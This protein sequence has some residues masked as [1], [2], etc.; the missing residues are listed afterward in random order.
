VREIILGFSKIETIN[1]TENVQIEAIVCPVDIN[2]R[3]AYQHARTTLVNLTDIPL[4]KLRSTFNVDSI[5]NDQVRHK[6][7]QKLTLNLNP[8]LHKVVSLQNV[9]E[10]QAWF[11]KT[12]NV[13]FQKLRYMN[14]LTVNDQY[15]GTIFLVPSTV[16]ANYY[17]GHTLLLKAAIKQI[18]SLEE[19]LLF[20]LTRLNTTEVHIHLK[21][22]V[23]LKL[24]P[25]IARY[26]IDPYA[27]EVFKAIHGMSL[28]SKDK[29][30]SPSF[31]MKPPV[32]EMV[33][34]T[35][36]CVPSNDSKI[37]WVTQIISCNST[38]P[39]TTLLVTKNQKH[40][41]G[42]GK[43]QKR[44]K[45]VR[46]I[47][48][49][50]KLTVKP[51]THSNTIFETT[52]ILDSN[53]KNEYTG[54]ENVD[55]HKVKKI[56]EVDR[57][58]KIISILTPLQIQHLS[59]GPNSSHNQTAVIPT[60]VSNM[61]D[62]ENEDPT[63]NQENQTDPRLTNFFNMIKC[64][65]NTYLVVSIQYESTSPVTPP[66]EENILPYRDD[67]INIKWC[68]EYTI[69]YIDADNKQ[70]E[71]NQ[72]ARRFIIKLAK[73][74]CKFVYIIE[75]IYWNQNDNGCTL[76]IISGNV[77]DEEHV[78]SEITKYASRRSSWGGKSVAK[79]DSTGSQIKY[80]TCRLIHSNYMDDCNAYS[81]KIIQ[82]AT[83]A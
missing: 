12:D 53:L 11:S 35:V 45:R 4:L 68:R 15:S 75:F 6:N 14:V 5:G 32:N 76:L 61:E 50:K 56:I 70:L 27:K 59:T 1:K 60:E 36:D 19:K 66:F 23:P 16:I 81:T 43:P 64:L 38:Y 54:L 40:Y 7:S 29:D 71:W 73:I 44:K 28:F 20:S 57:K 46:N 80:K 62:C 51:G 39:F 17:L 24:A 34:W 63:D 72:S 10:I 8:S 69:A 48:Y 42:F 74:D 37:I 47:D 25:H 33:T 55:I 22:N 82:L 21:D 78:V 83:S 65:E 31:Y 52:E 3:P 77:L 9:T 41:Q 2:D 67:L 30:Q 58:K 13:S 26:E 79:S 49:S 18:P